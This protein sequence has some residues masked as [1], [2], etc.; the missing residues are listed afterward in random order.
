MKALVPSILFSSLALTSLSTQAATPADTLVAVASLEGIITFD[1][2]ESFETT[3]SGNIPNLYQK[4]VVSD[5]TTPEKL[6][7]ELASEWQVGSDGHSLTFTL[8]SGVKFASGNPVR[9]EDVIY[10]LSRGV[11]LK[12][13]PSFILNELGWTP[14]NVD[15][16]L[17][18][19]ADNKVEIKWPANIGKELALNL[20]STN[21]A[22]VVDEK[23]L[24]QHQKDNDFGNDWLRSHSAGAGA[25]Q[26]SQ[27]VP[28]EAL[29][30][31]RNSYAQPQAKLNKILFKNVA[32]A[33]TRRLLLQKGDTDVAYDLGADQF[34]AVSKE[35][36][37]KLVQSPA[38]R[39]Y[40]L[41]FNTGNKD[42]PALGN[43]ALWQ[44]ARWLVDYQDI[45]KTLLRG[46]Y[47]VH[48]TFLP[49]GINGAIDDQP[50]KLDVDKAKTILKEGGIAPGTQLD[51]III[52]QPPYT[53]VAQALQA[54]FAKADIKI[55]IH[56]VVES[57]LWTR[58]RS[59]NF[60]SIFIYWGADYL[61][62]NTNASTF[63][64][65]VEG[66]PKTLAW[67]TQWKIPAITAQTRAAAQEQDP[68]KRA[69]L[70]AD[71]QRE[72]QKSSP[73]VV[74]LQGQNIVAI[75]DNVKGANL[76]IA[77]TGLYLDQIT[78]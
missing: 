66:G 77:S 70:Y 28:H 34:A 31:T 54:S 42:V 55:N 61:D 64:S 22:A 2:A 46:Q 40:Y 65:N 1:P 37:I 44:A 62:P 19:V 67:R 13:A 60:Q 32:D 56:P 15:S 26:I 58:M 45:S 38:A 39:I 3:S 12:K 17:T 29:I 52:N 25:Y 72:L 71:L 30:F 43:P 68:T 14:E 16:Y 21:I 10:S 76:T 50:F 33:G 59:Q 74:A 78:K 75:R 36:G 69:Q 53:D 5:R 11:K 6:T 9:P 47:T 57:D 35:A 63:A 18:K 8:K 27:Y 24:T 48:Q 23:L 51:L 49:I 20:L 4:L 73:Y 41:G 7:P